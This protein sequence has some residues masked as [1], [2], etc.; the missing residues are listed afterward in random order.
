[1]KTIKLLFVMMFFQGNFLQACAMDARQK[2]SASD[3][4]AIETVK[5]VIDY[6]FQVDQAMRMQFLQDRHNPEVIEKIK[7]MDCVHTVKMKEIIAFHG[8]PTISKFGA[9]TDAQAWLLVQHADH[10]LQFQEQCLKLL[11]N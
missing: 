10:D 8:W 7:A 2:N 4:H 6:M 11:Q 3:M 9:D 1:M 5:N